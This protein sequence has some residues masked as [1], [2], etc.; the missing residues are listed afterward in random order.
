[1]VSIGCSRKLQAAMAAATAMRAIGSHQNLSRKGW[2]SVAMHSE[3]VGT[4]RPVGCAA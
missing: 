1:L 4:A 2:E 3:S